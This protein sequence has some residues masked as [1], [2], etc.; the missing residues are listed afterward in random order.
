MSSV[1]SM[2]NSMTEIVPSEPPRRHDLSPHADRRVLTMLRL[3]T[4]LTPSIRSPLLARLGRSRPLA[5]RKARPDLL[6]EPAV[7][8]RVVERRPSEGDADGWVRV[9]Q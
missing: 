4:W 2:R 5:C 6:E 1:K 8:V 7:D 3:Q 9:R